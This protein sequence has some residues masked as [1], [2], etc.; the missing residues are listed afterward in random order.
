MRM[1]IE[2]TC[3]CGK[4]LQVSE[5]FS[6]R[7]GQCPACGGLLQIP[8][9]NDTVTAD[10]S[11]DKTAQAVFAAPGIPRPKGPAA[12]EDAVTTTAGS[13]DQLHDGERGDAETDDNA[14]LTAVGCVLTLLSVAI[15][16]AVAI[17]LV[18]WRDPATGRPLPRILAILSPLLIGAAVHGI[19]SLFLKIL[20]VQV[21]S[22]RR[23]GTRD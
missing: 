7:Q 1:P 4:R 13:A 2:L 6:G 18:R 22:N 17:P 21:W 20:G 10:P 9:C 3:S 14:K 23:T 8:P 5:E 12:P 11:S 16:F 19:G 15:I